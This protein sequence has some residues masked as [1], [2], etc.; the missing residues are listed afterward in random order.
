MAVRINYD[1]FVGQPIRS[2]QTFLRRIAH[3]YSDIPGVIPDGKFG[4]QTKAAVMGFQ[5]KFKMEP[6]GVVDNATW[7]KILLVYGDII[8][9]EGE[10][11]LAEIYPAGTCVFLPGE[12]NE[13]LYVIQAMMFAL[14]LH[15]PNIDPAAINGI[16]DDA[17]VRVV[18]QF[19]KAFGM[20]E[21]GMIE[22]NFWNKLAGLYASKISR[23][24]F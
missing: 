11:E 7:D 13:N 3:T 4:E 1:P 20:Q 6:N 15:F 2:L 5:S 17:N 18:K 8:E 19:Q 22:K 21:N 24:R 23:N 12:K 16:N 10:P 14:S 9:F